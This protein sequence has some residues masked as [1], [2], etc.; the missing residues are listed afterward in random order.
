MITEWLVNGVSALVAGIMGL[1]ESAIEVVAV[2]PTPMEF[3][4]F[5]ADLFAIMHRG[6]AMTAAWLPWDFWRVV[7]GAMVTVFV[8]VLAAGVLFNVLAWGFW[9]LSGLPMFPKLRAP[10][11]GGWDSF[12]RPR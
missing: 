5:S 2:V 12:D 10:F 1:L 8:V 4:S 7:L 6:V 3:L 9:A 11:G